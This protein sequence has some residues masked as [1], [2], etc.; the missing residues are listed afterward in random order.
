MGRSMLRSYQRLSLF[1]GFGRDSRPAL[2]EAAIDAE[3]IENAS[4]RRVD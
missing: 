4:N 2:N 3:E 1:V